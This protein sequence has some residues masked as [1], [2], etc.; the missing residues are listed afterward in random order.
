MLRWCNAVNKYNFT[1]QHCS[2]VK[3]Q[4]ADAMSGMHLTKCGWAKC[5]DCKGVFAPFADK[6]ESI[7]TRHDEELIIKLILAP[8]LGEAGTGT[9]TPTEV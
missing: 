7:L 4:K 5:P 2:S 8:Q 3:H 9:N 6:D 1:I